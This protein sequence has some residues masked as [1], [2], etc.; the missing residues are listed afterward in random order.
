[1]T[2][3]AGKL[4][5]DCYVRMDIRVNL[6]T[7]E[8]INM[9][10]ANNT[11][12]QVDN[13][14]LEDLQGSYDVIKELLSNEPFYDRI[15]FRMNQRSDDGRMIHVDKLLAILMMFSHSWY[16][17]NIT[18]R[19]YPMHYCQTQ[20]VHKRFM[21]QDKEERNRMLRDMAPIFH[22]IFELWDKIELELPEFKGKGCRKSFKYL[23]YTKYKDGETVGKTLFYQNDMQY[24]IP[25]GIVYPAIAA[26][27]MLTEQDKDG[28]YYWKYDPFIVWSELK[29]QTSFYILMSDLPT[30]TKIGKSMMTYQAFHTNMALYLKEKKL[31]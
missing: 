23:S 5:D 12:V 8:I 30:P 22:D 11:S 17:N 29:A 15:Q 6:S 31:A 20:N 4:S 27:R 16:D 3:E 14:S 26:F 2:K 13:R 1:M 28:R 21:E 9:V 18:N 24:L 10:A 25:E 19:D 7:A